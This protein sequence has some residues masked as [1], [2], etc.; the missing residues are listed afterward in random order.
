MVNPAFFERASDALFSELTRIL[1]AEKPLDLPDLIAS[2]VN[3][4]AIPNLL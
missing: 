4:E 1:A 2:C 3:K